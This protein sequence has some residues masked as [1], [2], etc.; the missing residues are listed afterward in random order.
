MSDLIFSEF[1]FKQL[2]RQN[3]L[4]ASGPILIQFLLF[5]V[6][7]EFLTT[8]MKR[9]QRKGGAGTKKEWKIR[10]KNCCPG[11]K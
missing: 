9:V 10:R 7:D 2:S 1:N 8:G 11:D 3:M 5:K 4:K 6:S